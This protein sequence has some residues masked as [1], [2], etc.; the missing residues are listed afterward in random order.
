MAKVG[1]AL[2]TVDMAGP[3]AQMRD[4]CLAFQR[5]G[6]AYLIISFI[7]RAA[8]PQLLVGHSR[9]A[10]QEIPDFFISREIAGTTTIFCAVFTQQA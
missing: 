9:F 3:K 5:E 8:I 2:V 4:Y 7:T 10:P 6:K 1:L